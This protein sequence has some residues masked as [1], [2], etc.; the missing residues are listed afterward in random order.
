MENVLNIKNL[1]VSFD[2]YDGTVQAVR[3][4]SLQMHAGEILAVV[5]ES[6]CGKSV[7]AQAIVGLNEG[8]TVKT[9]G[10]LLEVGGIDIL[11][12]SEKVM[13][14]VRG[15]LAGMVFQDPLTSLNPTM[16]VGTQITEA[17][18]R[19]KKLNAAQCKKEAV[20]LLEL[21]HIP[22]A[23]MRAEQ[24]PHQFSGGMRQRIM[25]AMALCGQPKL[26]IADEP[27]T[28]LDV[29]IQMQILKLLAQIRKKEGT[30][31]LL[32]THDLGVVANIADR[33][34][35]MYAGEIVESGN[36][37]EVFYDPAHP[38][39]KG[40]LESLP[41]PKGTAKLKSIPGSPPDLYAPPTGC[42]FAA[43]CDSCMRIC[44]REEPGE[45]VLAEGHKASCW[46]LHESFL[47]G[48]ESK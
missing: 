23:E 14:E 3:G 47:K 42:S 44:L 21:V 28:A 2:I 4:V 33:V 26:L 24:Y 45:I 11:H 12:A 25:I 17:L 6:G 39:T 7:T 32:I 37:E 36:L 1:K 13:Q 5:G 29:T 34:A 19:S 18:Y 22:D 15:N 31:I 20:R 48:V 38:Y 27:T 16:K 46:K 35:V 8:T 9:T 30:A 41:L 43:R 10:E 40:L